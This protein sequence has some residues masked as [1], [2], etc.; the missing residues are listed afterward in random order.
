MRQASWNPDNNSGGP[1][2][3]VTDMA[4]A[5]GGDLIEL[6]LYDPLNATGAGG[7]ATPGDA[8]LA[9]VDVWLD[10][11]ETDRQL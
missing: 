4:V 7:P 11:R 2:I 3:R 1:A 8:A 9:V 10:D 6:P 5:Q